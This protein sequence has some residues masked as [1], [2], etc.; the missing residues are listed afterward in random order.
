MN[1][2]ISTWGQVIVVDNTTENQQFAEYTWSAAY[3]DYLET[4]LQQSG[5]SQRA[6]SSHQNLVGAEQH[7]RNTSNMGVNPSQWHTWGI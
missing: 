3:L 6:A 5:A 7:L 1:S 4:T 2:D